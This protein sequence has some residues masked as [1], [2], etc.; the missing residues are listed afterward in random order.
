LFLFKIDLYI[1]DQLFVIDSENFKVI[2]DFALPI[3]EGTEDTVF[4]LGACWHG[5]R[6]LFA[7]RQVCF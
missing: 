3:I 5:K 4:A 6:N 1:D 2:K 7:Y